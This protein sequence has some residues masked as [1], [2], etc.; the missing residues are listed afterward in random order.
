M[1]ATEEEREE[2]DRLG[3]ELGRLDE[4]LGRPE[5]LD[6]LDEELGLPVVR[7]DILDDPE[8]PKP[9]LVPPDPPLPLPL[10]RWEV[11][12]LKVVGLSVRLLI[13]EAT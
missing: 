4:E 3:E 8:L 2:L 9:V 10:R 5:E 6:R 7:G 11:V 12:V 13:T 1:G